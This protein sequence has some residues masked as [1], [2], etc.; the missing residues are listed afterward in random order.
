MK[1][2]LL[3][4]SDLTRMDVE[5]LFETTRLL[6][7]GVI[8]KIL[9]GKTLAMIFEK[10]SLRTRVTFEVGMTQLEGYA[11]YLNQNDI[12]LGGRETVADAAH[13][14]ERWV[15]GIVARTFR[16][17]TVV[18]L[19]QNS[20]VP[21]INALS[22][23]EH[24]CQA[25]ADFFTILEKKKKFDGLKI[26]FIGD[27]NNVCNSL[28]LLSSILGTNFVVACPKGYE[29]DIGIMEKARKYNRESGGNLSI[30][31]DPKDA[32]RDADVVYTDVWISM[33]DEK[34]RDQR[35]KAF[36][37][38]QVNEELLS[39]AKDDV[40]VMHCLPAKRGVEISDEVMDGERSV[41][42]DEAE[43]RLHVQK[44]ILV[45]LLIAGDVRQ[46]PLF[47]APQQK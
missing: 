9:Y 44:A 5:A 14:L 34:E 31:S 40:I 20:R 21:V 39:M 1:K 29:P 42:F 13:N 45:H 18:E 16:H 6:K 30:I 23:I 4:I 35:L 8:K 17:E 22:D 10:P 32:A 46:I 27:G 11:I 26:T 3:S 47:G 19:A 38:F 41:V 25:L 37:G 2:D 33:G 7:M 36:E 24:P 28:A 12:K 43:N 15:D